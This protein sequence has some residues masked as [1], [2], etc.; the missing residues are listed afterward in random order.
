MATNATHTIPKK[1]ALAAE[2]RAP[3]VWKV[4][5]AILQPVAS[6]RL[7]VAL[8]A[9]SIFIVFVGTLAQSREGMW[10]VMDIY[11]RSWLAFVKVEVF[12]PFA[13][14]PN[15]TETPMRILTSL[16]CL[17]AGAVVAAI[18]FCVQKHRWL[19]QT[20]GCLAAAYGLVAA[21]CALIFGGFWFVGG[22]TI[23]LLLALNLLA[24]HISRF[25][26]QAKGA[27]LA[28]GLIVTLVG[29]YVTFLIIAAGHNADGLQA[30]PVFSMATL[31]AFCRIGL[32]LGAIGLMGLTGVVFLKAP[33][34]MLEI[35]VLFGISLIFA[36]VA[37]WLWWAGEEAYLGD[38][39]MRILWQLMQA[40]FAAVILL[41]GCVLVFKK[42]GGIVLIHAGVAL[43]MFGEWF[44]SGYAVEE[45]LII[46]E[47]Q[48]TNY[49]IDIR[50]TELAIVNENYSETEDDVVVIPGSLLH[51]SQAAGK[52]ITHEHLPFDIKITKY[53][54]N[55]DVRPAT[56]DDD[57]PATAGQG[58]LYVAEP[59]RKSSGADTS[60]EIDLASLYA[61]VYEK[62]KN[63][64][65]GTY[66]LSQYL[67]A[68]DIYEPIEVK[69]TTYQVGLRFKRNYKPYTMRLEDVSKD[70]YVGTNTPRSY[71]SLVALN[72][73]SRNFRRDDIK[74]WMNN[75]LRY[76]GETFYQ[77]GYQRDSK[78]G[79]ETTTLQV[80]TNTGWMMPYVACMLAAT[81]MCAHFLVV[82]VRFLNRRHEAVSFNPDVVVAKVVEPP[83][84]KRRKKNR[85]AAPVESTVASRG[86][87]PV[88]VLVPALI[89]GVMAFY[90]LSKARTPSSPDGFNYEEFG[91][92]PVVYEGRVKPIDTLARNALKKISNRETFVDENGKKQP[93][94]RW[95]LEMVARPDLASQRETFR[96]ESLDVLQTLGLNR[97]KGFRYSLN[98][99]RGEDEV[100][101]ELDTFQRDAKTARDKDTAELNV[102][103]RK[104]LDTDNRFRRYT[105]LNAA[106][107][108]LPFPRFP[109]EAE[110][111]KDQE[112]A[113]KRMMRIRQMMDAVPKSERALV[114]MQAPLAV[115]DLLDV[116]EDDEQAELEWTHYSTAMN[117]AYA[118]KLSDEEI[119][120]AV[121]SLAA[122]FDA[123]QKGDTETF[124][125][126]VANY[127]ELL[128][129]V[130]P[131]QLNTGKV[132]FE[133]FMNQ[134]APFYYSIVLCVA[135]FVLAACAW[136]GWNRIFN[137][138]AFWL[139]VFTL[140]L[141]TVAIIGR[142]YISGRPPVT[143][144]YTSAIFIG[145]AAIAIGLCLEGVFRLGIGN[146]VGSVGGF[147]SLMIAYN[148]SAS[149][150]T[151]TVMQA[152]LDTQFWLATHV[153]CITFGYAVTFIAGLLAVVYVI[154][155]VFT[156]LLGRDPE[157]G[158]QLTRMIYGTVCF[159]IFFSFVGTVL[160]GLWAD[161][162]WGRFW[163]WDPKENG[164]LI[165]VIWNAIVL[166]ARW[167]GLVKERGLALLAIGGNIVTSWSWFGVNEL[168][169]GLHSYGFT[170]GVLLALGLFVASQSALIGVG[171]LPK[172]WWVSYADSE[173][174]NPL[175][176]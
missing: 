10:E 16:E 92:L 124:N 42:R 155:G 43:L 50:E 18:C 134:F 78:T 47:G 111:N 8:F 113:I 137:R 130:P 98:E 57:N 108:P 166:H 100:R 103:E 107:D 81:G 145:W 69:G 154:L 15:M 28:I 49:A 35:G 51:D 106:F 75:P 62:S 109:T 80:V 133:S 102:Y 163:G 54:P 120:P 70:D 21:N 150:D 34:R 59:L 56:D 63:K 48:A 143:N 44:V 112:E 52:K 46:E 121:L 66:L 141:Y 6:L 125:N 142:I 96:I 24:A 91:K 122:I 45:R 99:I 131:G 114:E 175:P 13:W 11:F 3:S 149:G 95:F 85:R 76:A 132:S 136:L 118:Q 157:L 174:E 41:V 148:L 116:D 84:R 153:V 40:E 165:I 53:L 115:P 173:V 158:K 22:A 36:S 20:Y 128:G 89:V 32:T 64:K 169:V 26:A 88:A 30:V 97:K 33:G 7:T 73:P 74:I 9:A 23:G 140:C 90:V 172:R 123:Y 68:V 67:S 93:A 159:A 129:D 58:R 25:K 87:S 83:S 60:G 139:L 61:E 94:T 104:L 152:V 29:I 39:G 167:G 31:W 4:I 86:H 82:L 37:V 135:A 65:I 160:G 144:L 151:F 156:P 110:F 162:S 101:E 161:D 17:L 146:L 5:Q 55:S 138:S 27:R 171:L 168:G 127:Q 117:R 176:A 105:L 19:W 72:D 170:E 71:S 164:A 77:S 79:K 12:F 14:F 147:G 38:A 119:N 1:P 126:E 2:A